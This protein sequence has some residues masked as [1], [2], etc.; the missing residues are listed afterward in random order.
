MA[1]QSNHSLV[2]TLPPHPT[3]P[4]PSKEQPFQRKLSK[5]EKKELK[6]QEKLRRAIEANENDSSVAEKLYTGMIELKRHSV[7]GGRNF[8][9]VECGW[10]EHCRG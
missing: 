1:F 6:K 10:R 7:A 3:T 4:V 5:R 9:G 8:T 2:H